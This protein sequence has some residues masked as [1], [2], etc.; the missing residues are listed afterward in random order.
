MTGQE[1]L[2]LRSGERSPWRQS[3]LPTVPRPHLLAPQEIRKYQGSGSRSQS[4]GTM[5]LIP[6]APFWRLAR[7]VLSTVSTTADRWSVQASGLGG[8]VPAALPARRIEALR[9]AAEAFMVGLFEDSNLC[10]I[11]ANL[12]T[13]MPKDVQ[14]ARRL[15]GE[16]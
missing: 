15:R 14:L 4:A 2:Q 6:R 13:I 8:G 11:H 1:S 7:E 3:P 9:E 16:V 5:K 10:A 12:V